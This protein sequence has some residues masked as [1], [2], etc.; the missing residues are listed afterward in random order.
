ME[1]MGLIVSGENLDLNLVEMIELKNHPW[2][3][4]V[5]FHPELKSRIVNVHP[6]FRDFIATA[7]EEKEKKNSV[8]ISNKEQVA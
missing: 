1:Q 2:F 6:L 7:I 8:I 4:G 3:V 5:Q